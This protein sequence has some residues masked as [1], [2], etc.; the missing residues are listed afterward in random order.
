MTSQAVNTIAKR[1]VIRLLGS[2]WWRWTR[3]LR[4]WLGLE[5]DCERQLQLLKKSKLV[6]SGHYFE[7][8]P[9]VRD[10]GIGA[11]THYYFFGA[12]EGRNPNRYFDTRWYLNQYPDVAAAGVNPLLHFIVHGAAERRNPGPDFDTGYYLRAN[13]DVLQARLNPLGH[14]LRYGATESRIAVAPTVRAPRP[15][16]PPTSAWAM[17]PPQEG[18]A[19]PP[20]DIIVPVYR[21][22]DDTLSCLYSVL[23]AK[24][25]TAYELVVINDASP[26]PELSAELRRL[27]AAGH[28]TLIENKANL[29]FVGTVNRG[30]HLHA[31]RDVLLL[32]SDTVVYN[33]WL[34]RIMAHAAMDDTIATIT[35]LSNNATICSYPRTLENNGYALELAYDALDQICAE[36][37]V[38]SSVDIPTGVGFCM[39]IRRASLDAVGYFDEEAFGRGYGEENDFCRRVFAM[40]WRNVLAGDVFV[41][42]TG[43]VSFADEAKASQQPAR[44][45]LLAKHPDYDKVI[46]AYVAHDPSL[47]LRRNIDL[48]RLGRLLAGRDTFL[49]VS[50]GRGGGTQKHIDDLAEMLRLDGKVAIQ[51]SP[52]HK[53]GCEALLRIHGIDAT[54]PN[55][56]PTDIVQDWSLT[57]ELCRRLRIRHIH[58]HSFADWDR[59]MLQLIP[60]LAAELGIQC[61]Y[62][63]HDYLPICPGFNLVERGSRYCGEAGVAQCLNC[64]NAQ[65]EGCNGDIEQW[66]ADYA[67]SLV[68]FRHVFVPNEDVERRLSG[69]FPDCAF[70]ERP[71]PEPWIR[72]TSPLRR[73]IATTPLS[74]AVVG[75]LSH[76]KGSA[77]LLACAEDA[78]IRQ[79]PI[80]FTVIGYTDIDAKLRKVPTVELLGRYDDA[81]LPSLLEQHAPG[82]ILF[83]SVCPETFMYTLS[84]AIHMGFYVAAFDIGAQASRIRQYG[85]G[86][87][88][89]IDDA[90]DGRKTNDRLLAAA[91]AVLP[92]SVTRKPPATYT[93]DSYYRLTDRRYVEGESSGRALMT[94]TFR[95]PLAVTS[96]LVPVGNRQ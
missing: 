59:R 35:P 85:F 46:G 3:V 53:G 25:N 34:D 11:A 13:P 51:L 68:R 26:E 71:H 8:C 74:V 67:E 2:R 58:V 21:G 54:L 73:D 27:A 38:N 1:D 43:E 81:N 60:D 55:L 30:M 79:L 10:S 15:V 64:Q 93:T 28:F 78:W 39:Y 17:L 44:A 66:R 70:S 88:L 23:A 90:H 37:N 86:H 82:I 94:N 87:L 24:Q 7:Q 36:V 42:H 92:L 80:H 31:Q 75:A 14:Y 52:A 61:D 57:V 83:P 65:K 40:G 33:D 62:T 63:A 50:H 22:Y 20:I 84:V 18:G 95:Y 72:S 77:A 96:K 89:S 6:D 76:N 16:A 19:A 45:A 48:G 9:D 47:S 29:G 49:F 5:F 12:D 32:N 56:S 41:R 91:T 69:Y 4:R